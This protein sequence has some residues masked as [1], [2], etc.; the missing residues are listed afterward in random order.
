M[1]LEGLGL[2]FWGGRNLKRDTKLGPVVITNIYGQCGAQRL[3]RFPS[4]H[5]TY[6][7]APFC[8]AQRGDQEQKP[9]L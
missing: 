1:C 9:A 8:G 2:R 3:V 5:L 7:E 4:D 6:S